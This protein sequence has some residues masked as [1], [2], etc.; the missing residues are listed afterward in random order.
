MT[1]PDPMIYSYLT[2]RI[3][4]CP[5]C[6]DR[7][8]VQIIIHGMPAFRPTPEEEDRVIFAGCVMFVSEDPDQGPPKWRCPACD[9]S[10]TGRGVVVTDPDGW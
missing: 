7:D 6:G 8:R 10:Y 5:Q 2:K 4:R 9:V 3:R 1:Q